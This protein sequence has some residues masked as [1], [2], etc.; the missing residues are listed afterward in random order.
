MKAV[1]KMS[2][3]LKMIGR[4][5]FRLFEGIYKIL[6]KLII[7]PISRLVY[8]ISK[9]LKSNNRINKMLNQ[10]HFLIVISLVFAVIC[11]LLIDNKVINLVENE[12]E[13]IKNVPVNLIYNEEAYVV[14]N[15]PETVDITI[16]GRK[17]DIYLAKQLGEFAVELDLSKYTEEGTRKVYFTYSKSIDT[18]KYIL[19]PSYLT[20]TIKDKVSEVHSVTYDLVSTDDLDEKLSVG[21]ISLDSSEVVVKGSQDTL[22]QISSIKALVSVSSD[23]YTE[24]DTYEMTNIPL[25]AY[26]KK[27]EIIKNLE[28]V[29]N[30]MT[31]TLVLKSYK[32]TVPLLINTT[33]NLING[34]AIASIT[35][36]N[37]SAF[38]LDIYGEENEIKNISN[39]PVTINV[40]GLGSESVKTYKVTLSKPA[41]VRHMSSKNVTITA[42][43]GDENQKA[44]TIKSID[45]KNLAD[46]Y[47]ANIINTEGVPVQVKGVQ[48]NISSIEANNVKAYV[49]LAGLT[50]GT[51]QLEV[52]IDNNNPLVKYVVSSTITVKI[53][54]D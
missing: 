9:L 40:D 54:K 29:P 32:S 42:T 27:G 25:V 4:F 22:D 20:V 31:G 30:V 15:V 8:N 19:D 33:G 45:G 5:L 28:I 36:N 37:S 18:V 6:D 48:S 43:F 44:L 3:F 53:T 50:E 47:S 26:N 2:K 14:E 34:K 1:K 23:E 39:V 10:P 11:F 41:G 49:D 13:V 35:V 51:H 24:A 38:S 7:M 16:T 46:G 21:S 12:A 17:S 52:K